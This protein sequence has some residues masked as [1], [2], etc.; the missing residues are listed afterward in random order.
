MIL[1]TDVKSNHNV[2]ATKQ[3]L[4][5]HVYAEMQENKE[6]VW[7]KMLR[8]IFSLKMFIINKKYV[9]FYSLLFLANKMNKK[10]SKKKLSGQYHEQIWWQ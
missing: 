2:E 1:K 10:V 6:M 8:V 4:Y 7:I 5:P 3:K 9:L